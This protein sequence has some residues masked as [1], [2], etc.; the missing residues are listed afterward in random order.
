MQGTTPATHV[1]RKRLPNFLAAA[2]GVLCLLAAAGW[3]RSYLAF[4]FL[5]AVRDHPRD[6]QW[7]RQIYTCRASHG[8]AELSYIRSLQTE[9]DGVESLR[10]ADR[11]DPHW[12]SV[13]EPPRAYPF[14]YGGYP[15]PGLGHLLGFEW[16]A[17]PMGF[18]AGSGDVWEAEI[19]LPYWLPVAAT[20]VLPLQWGV[21]RLRR[22]PPGACE[23]CGYD[24]R[25][26][27]ERCPECG[28]PPVASAN[29]R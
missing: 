25:A 27:P 24:R 6:A 2:S 23:S 28:T 3:V 18:G 11:R 13:H 26:S 19:V 14:R 4:D 7:L 17:G 16:E 5:S 10:A 15:Q 12:L 22:R 1:R 21:R 20:A 29:R 8:G 9:P